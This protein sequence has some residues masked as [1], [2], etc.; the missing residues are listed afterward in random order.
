[1]QNYIVKAFRIDSG[2]IMGWG[3]VR[4][5]GAL[6]NVKSRLVNTVDPIHGKFYMAWPDNRSDD[7]G[8]YAQNISLGTPNFAP[9]LPL[10]NAHSGDSILCAGATLNLAYSTVWPYFK[11]NE[12]KVVLSN[13]TGDFTHADTLKVI[14]D[15]VSGT[16]MVSLP[17]TL[18]DGNG[19]K[20]RVLA[21]APK[22]QGGAASQ[23]IIV[24]A[25]PKV[26]LALEPDTV[27]Y[28]SK[29]VQLRGGMP[30]GGKYLGEGIDSIGFVTPTKMGGGLHKVKYAYTN[31][32]GCSDT[33]EQ[34]F[35]VKVITDVPQLNNSGLVKLYPNPVKNS[36]YLTAEETIANGRISVY[37][38]LGQLVYADMLNVNAGTS[39][40]VNTQVWPAGIYAVV[41]E[42][43]GNKSVMQ[44]VKQ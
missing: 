30:V 10:V 36:L 34:D 14:A 32:H 35:Y 5:M 4:T 29:G 40:Q 25:L 21:N 1:M 44:I 37:N 41:I 20:I 11:D 38:V 28:W 42:G 18:S 23:D 43:D 16:A 15:S 33:A 3:G 27:Y 13:G 8:I 7:N 17:D 39:V 22:S 31:E 2:G 9:G 19:Y 12:F 26:T 6:Q 24:Y